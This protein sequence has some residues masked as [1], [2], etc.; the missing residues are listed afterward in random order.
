MGIDESSRF[1]SN[2]DEVASSLLEEEL[3]LINLSSGVY[4]SMVNSGSL[5]WQ[6]IDLGFSVSE[7][8]ETV[9]ARYRVPA[10]SVRPD[11]HA[12]LQQMLAERIFLPEPSPRESGSYTTD[13]GG[14]APPY[15]RPVLNVYRDMGDLLALDAPMPGMQ[16]IPWKGK[17]R[18]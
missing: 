2:S 18:S 12:L 7:T 17:P 11:V 6:L 13:D 14:A 5:I 8:I 3:V 9:A 15:E 16:D 4:Y 1:E 10:E